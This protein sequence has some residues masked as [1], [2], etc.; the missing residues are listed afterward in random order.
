MI[1]ICTYIIYKLEFHTN[2]LIIGHILGLLSVVIYN[3]FDIKMFNEKHKLKELVDLAKRYIKYPKYLLPSTLAS[4]LSSS[5]PIYL[6]SSFFSSQLS[7]YYFF[8][9]RIVSLPISLFGNSIGEVYRQEASVN[10]SKYGDCSYIYLKTLKKLILLGTVPLLLF[11]FL[12]EYFVPYIWGSQWEYSGRLTKYF[13]FLIFFQFISTP[14]SYTI[15]FNRYVNFDTYLQLFRLIFT[16]ISFY[17][18]YILKN[19]DYAIINYVFVYSVYY[20]LH[21]IYQYKSS[22]GI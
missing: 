5:L 1:S 14:L 18:G 12:G 13:S 6:I 2:S 7:G 8:T 21:S 4:E 10:Y 17:I 20:I 3:I 16:F 15:H 9:L 22:L 19:F 11:Y